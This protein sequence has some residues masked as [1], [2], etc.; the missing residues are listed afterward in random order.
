ML[1]IRTRLKKNI[2]YYSLRKK[3][4]KLRKIANKAKTYRAGDE[5]VPKNDNLLN[6]ITL[7]PNK[8]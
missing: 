7:F 3:L 5:W 4:S 6:I 2:R 1:P 8:V